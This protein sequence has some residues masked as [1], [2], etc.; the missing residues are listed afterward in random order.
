[1]S[2]YLTSVISFLLLSLLAIVSPQTGNQVAITSPNDDDVVQ[3]TFLVM[4]NTDVVGFESYEVLF[5]YEDGSNDVTWFLIESSDQKVSNGVLATWDT[6]Q[7][8]DGNYRLALVVN[9]A[10]DKPERVVRTNIRVRN[11]TPVEVEETVIEEAAPIE[12]EM[13]AAA[14]EEPENE[15]STSTLFGSM[16]R[17][18][19]YT[20]IAIVIL[21][22]ILI[23]VVQSRRRNT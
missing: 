13:N 8:T 4:G 1:M 9:F 20:V 3:G 2:T 12:D 14:V 5:A 11:Y 19:L 16:L 22:G 23:A 18:M 6:S 7:I 10:D 21:G 15:T 17:G